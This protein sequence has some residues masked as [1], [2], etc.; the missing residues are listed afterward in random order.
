MTERALTS[1]ACSR[2]RCKSSGSTVEPWSAGRA[3]RASFQARHIAVCAHGA[4]GS[5]DGARLTVPAHGTYVAGHTIR[6][7]G[8]VGSQGTEIPG[9]TWTRCHSVA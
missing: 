8:I 9:L 6:G 4:A 1:P 5:R 7:G 3:L 2:F